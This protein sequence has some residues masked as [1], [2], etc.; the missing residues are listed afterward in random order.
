MAALDAAPADSPADLAVPAQ[1]PP[2]TPESFDVDVDAKSREIAAMADAESEVKPAEPVEGEV[3][4]KPEGEEEAKVDEGPAESPEVAALRE[5]KAQIEAKVEALERR[6]NEWRESALETLVQNRALADKVQLLEQYLEAA[7]ISV[8]E[9]DL[10]ILDLKAQG[11]AGAVK[12]QAA[13]YGQ[14][15]QQEA[16]VT[17]RAAEMRMEAT[18]VADKNGLPIDALVAR[19][20]A[21]SD[22]AGKTVS[23]EEAG[24]SLM[25]DISRATTARQVQANAAVKKPMPKAAGT[26]SSKPNFA[27]PTTDEG[28]RQRLAAHGFKLD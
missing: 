10:Q 12:D 22:K 8:D 23:F 11:Y 14:T 27:P 1:A 17:A 2:S 20:N 28:I 19:W 18:T 15:R 26:S 5:E 25:A 9:R 24:K 16:A 13:K 3:E 7:G 4:A 21:L 6:D